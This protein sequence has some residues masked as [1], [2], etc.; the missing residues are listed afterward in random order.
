MSSLKL[1]QAFNERGVYSVG[2][3][4]NVASA[5]PYDRKSIDS[6][7]SLLLPPSNGNGEKRE[8][9]LEKL[10]E[11]QSKLALISGKRSHGQDD[12]ERFGQVKVVLQRTKT[13]LNQTKSSVLTYLSFLVCVSS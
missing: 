2:K 10:K 1:A 4:D 12:V 5:Q 6:V 13:E 7:I 11:L 3:L 8:Y 9:S